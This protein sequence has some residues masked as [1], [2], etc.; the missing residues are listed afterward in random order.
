MGSSIKKVPTSLPAK[1]VGKNGIGSHYVERAARLPHV[2][3]TNH[4]RYVSW[5]QV[6]QAFRN[7]TLSGPV[8]LKIW[9]E[10]GRCRCWRRAEPDISK[11]INRQ[12][13]TLHR[14]CIISH[15]CIAMEHDVYSWH[16][17]FIY[18]FDGAHFLCTY[19]R[20]STKRYIN[21]E[22]H[23][24]YFQFWAILYS[25]GSKVKIV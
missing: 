17:G 22:I 14:N 18:I 10:A 9:K 8:P 11:Q 1:E 3:S 19:S 12:C 24:T 5:S 25:Q 4:A 6:S 2:H 20:T 13:L 15:L 16:I 21:W 23:K 7:M